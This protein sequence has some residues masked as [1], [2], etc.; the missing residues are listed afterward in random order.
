MLDW[1]F[2]MLLV[3][4][5]LF[6][7]LTVEFDFGIY[8]NTVFV[9]ISIIIFFVLSASIMQIE[10]PHQMYNATSGNIETG[11]HTFT[12]PVSPYLSYLFQFLAIVMMVYF[13]GYNFGTVILKKFYR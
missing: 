12:S 6:V 1:L 10:I 2:I 9:M 4:S 8:W 7:L 13:V 11:Y 5:V 3:I